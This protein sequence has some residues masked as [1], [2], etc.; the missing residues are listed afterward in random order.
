MMVVMYNEYQQERLYPSEAN[1]GICSGGLIFLFCFGGKGGQHLLEPENPRETI[2]WMHNAHAHLKLNTNL[3]KK[4][5]NVSLRPGIIC[6]KL[7]KKI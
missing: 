1:T 5:A 3:F 7:N 4:F 6:C 2:D